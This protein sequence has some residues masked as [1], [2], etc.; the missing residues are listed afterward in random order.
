MQFLLFQPHQLQSLSLPCITMQ[1]RISDTLSGRCYFND[2]TAM[3][4][5]RNLS[6]RAARNRY[7]KSC[8]FRILGHSEFSPI[9]FLKHVAERMAR[10][11]CLVSARSRVPEN[12]SSLGRSNPVAGSVDSQRTAAVEDCIE[13]IHSSFSRSNSTTTTSHQ[14]FSHALWSICQAQILVNNQGVLLCFSVY[15]H[16]WIV[17]MDSEEEQEEN[18]GKEK[19][20]FQKMNQKWKDDLPFPFHLLHLFYSQTDHK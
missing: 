10:V 5:D 15:Y 16:L 9:E 7:V 18:Y 6:G 17:C 3:S 12:S 19:V 4:R 11:I 13:F 20:F 2:N 1:T 14:D 8:S